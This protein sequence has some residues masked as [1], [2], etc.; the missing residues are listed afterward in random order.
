M[1]KKEMYYGWPLIVILGLLYFLTS[2][3]ILAT[4]QMVNPVMMKDIGLSA[5]MLG[6]GFTV[7]V[8]CSAIPAPLVGQLV[9]KIGS[10][11]TIALGGGLVTIGSLCMIFFCTNPVTYIIFFGVFL[12]TAQIM[13]GQIAV[14]ATVGVW[15][16][17]HRG[18]AMS[19]A[20]GIGGLASFVAPLVVTPLMAS[21]G[22]WR[23]GWYMLAA[24]GVIVI[25]L[26][27][28][29]VRSRPEDMGLEIDGGAVA[30]KAEAA[31][32]TKPS[33]VFRNH[34]KITYRQ[35]IKTPTFWFLAVAGCGGFC[36]FALTTSQGVLNFTTLGFD[37]MF[38]A[39]AA[40]VMGIISLLAK[41]FSGFLAD[42][43]DP[44]KLL[45]IGMACQIVGILLGAFASAG[46]MVYAYYFLIG[47]G[48]GIVA[49]NLP[50]SVANYFG[51]A[52]FSKNLGTTMLIGGLISSGVSTF[53]G[54]I[55]DATGACMAG[56]LGVAALLVVCVICG[57]LVR[58]PKIKAES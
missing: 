25:I 32:E 34:E 2:G 24:F 42:H 41:T 20:M 16:D 12:G 9:A 23:S 39:G 17:K 51:V 52:E 48:F 33:K 31:K 13:A 58:K 55:F 53:V 4:A 50:T 57:F 56:F 27:M 22:D 47:L 1:E 18:K 44:V 11:N 21:T 19:I 26:S 6:L 28:V 43:I 38:I 7:F 37:P 5:T 49:T 46:W 35:A 14:Q 3:F 36:G 15:F 40:S 10:R 8:L 45:I 29:F 54:M 30:E